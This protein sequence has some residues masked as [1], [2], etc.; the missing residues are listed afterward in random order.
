M[1]HGV[2]SFLQAHF[3]NQSF[4]TDAQVAVSAVMNEVVQMPTLTDDHG[5]YSVSG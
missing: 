3:G 1:I 2:E 4:I 5:S